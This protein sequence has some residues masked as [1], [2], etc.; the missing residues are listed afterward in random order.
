MDFMQKEKI[1]KMFS[2]WNELVDER[3]AINADINT[4]LKKDEEYQKMLKEKKEFDKKMGE[5]RELV[6]QKL[7]EQKGNINENIKLIISDVKA[8]LDVKQGIVS[9]IFRFY[10]KKFDHGIDELDTITMAY[11]QVFQEEEEA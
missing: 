2:N 9:S 5:R 1:K 10:K 4:L 3:K 8:D 7:L 6:T 11:L